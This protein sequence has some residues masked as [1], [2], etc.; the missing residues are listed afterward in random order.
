MRLL[1]AEDDAMIGAAVRDR[2]HGQ[3]VAVDWS[4]TAARPTQPS[5]ATCTISCS[6]I[7][8]CPDARALPC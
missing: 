4:V 1:L 5:R 3:G 7:S 8:A 6:S 2:L